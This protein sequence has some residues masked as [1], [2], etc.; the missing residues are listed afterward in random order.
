MLG[1]ALI[2]PRI[3]LEKTGS[4]NVWGTPFLEGLQ[5]L[6]ISPSR[7]LFIFSPHLCLSVVGILFLIYSMYPLIRYYTEVTSTSAFDSKLYDAME[8]VQPV[9]T[10]FEDELDKEGA[11]S[12]IALLQKA[13]YVDYVVSPVVGIEKDWAPFYPM[14]ISMILL[15]LTA[16]A[17]F[18]PYGGILNCNLKNLFQVGLTDLALLLI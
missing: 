7:G 11:R 13:T 9:G 10:K 18:D 17:W 12:G 8:W 4:S 16:S 15:V 6:F 14:L 3:A 1:Q 2:G 5:Y